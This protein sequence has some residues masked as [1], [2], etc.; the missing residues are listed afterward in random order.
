MVLTQ[1]E[2]QDN[3][4]I[5]KDVEVRY[6][7]GPPVLKDVS[8]DLKPGEI[9]GLVGSSGAGKTTAMRVM[10]GQLKPT[11]GE[12]Y[13][14]H[15]NVATNAHDI[16]MIIGFVPQL[17]YLSLYYEFSAVQNA[18]FFGRN[19]NLSDKVIRKRAEEI[20]GILGFS[21]D[22]MNQP[23]KYLSGGEKKRASIAVGLI[24]IPD[25]LF[26]DEPTTGLDPH[27]RIQVLNYLL[28]INQKYNTTLVIVSHDLEVADYCTKVAIVDG[29]RLVGFGRPNELIASLPSQG[30]H[31]LVKFGNLSWSQ[32]REIKKLNSVVY[33]LHAGRNK[34]KLF[35]EDVNEIHN[36]YKQL[37]KIGLDPRMMV[38]DRCT[39]LDYFRLKSLLMES[40]KNNLNNKQ[41]I[42]FK[43]VV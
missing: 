41:N 28:K 7:K 27:L 18:Q 42:K 25:V 21:N 20:L 26:L 1:K 19:F 31:L 32:T 16:S 8:I 9:L 22:M 40:E 30:F 12:A 14:S 29:G 39:F 5:L 15:F 3:T 23:I 4:I 13:T 34:L 24:N 36:I 35:L 17:E 10:T 37:R 33:V 43:A 2:I 6:G 11:K 38:I